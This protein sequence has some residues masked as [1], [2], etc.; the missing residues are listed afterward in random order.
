MA[1]I[2][3]THQ[4]WDAMALG[5]IAQCREDVIAFAKAENAKVLRAP[6]RPSS[7]EQYVD[8]RKGAPVESMRRFG[9]VEFHYF[10]I[11]EVVEAAMQALFDLSPVD[12][13]DYRNSHMI[14]VNGA[15]V[16]NLASWS[17]NGDTEV[18]IANPLIYSRKIE[19]GLMKMRVSGTERVYAQA[20]QRVR[21]Q[22]GNI[23]NVRATFV[24]V[25]D[26]PASS[27][28]SRREIRSAEAD[29]RRPAMRIWPR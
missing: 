10:R 1:R 6:P 11:A 15:A 27:G 4:Q 13:G 22:Y 20:V 25:T 3:S 21:R 17:P 29:A 24:R 8:G 23:A 7:F 26:I 12:S 5:V 9:V 16:R 28:M 18:V 14:F 19:L 2:R